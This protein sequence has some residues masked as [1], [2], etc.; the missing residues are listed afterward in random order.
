ME[1]SKKEEEET[2]LELLENMRRK[3]CGK[4]V[5][6]IIVEKGPKQNNCPKEEAKKEKKTTIG[7]TT[8]VTSCFVSTFNWSKFA[9]ECAI[10]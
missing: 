9:I 1:N 2:L 5:L 10:L 6:K 7:T 8:M 3:V 4:S